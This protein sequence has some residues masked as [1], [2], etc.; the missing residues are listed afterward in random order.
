MLDKSLD[1]SCRIRKQLWNCKPELLNNSGILKSGYHFADKALLR[2]HHAGIAEYAEPPVQNGGPLLEPNGI[3]PAKL[4]VNVN[5]PNEPGGREE[6]ES[7]EVSQ[8]GEFLPH[9]GNP[10]KFS[11]GNLT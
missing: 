8:A 1:Q 2:R 5:E 4:D 3:S 7:V 6:I 9:Q 11:S 10:H